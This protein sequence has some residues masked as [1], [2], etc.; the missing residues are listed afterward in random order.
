MQNQINIAACAFIALFLGSPALAHGDAHDHDPDVKVIPAEVK[1]Q[2][3]PQ[4]ALEIVHD[5]YVSNIVPIFR[6]KCFD[7]HTDR[8]EYPWYYKIPGIKQWIDSDISQAREHLDMSRGFPFASKN[9]IDHDLEEIGEVI[10]SKEMPPKSYIF[11]HADARI[12]EEDKQVLLDWV[13]RSRETL[14]NKP[15]T[16]KR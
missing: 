7:C 5:D 16:P 12:S 1:S 6:R 2:E 4:D 13:K 14:S 11:V 9:S 8:T 15:S 3:A 10:E